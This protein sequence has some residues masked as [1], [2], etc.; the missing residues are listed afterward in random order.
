MVSMRRPGDCCA[1]P[2]PV[3]PLPAAERDALV[4][5]LRALGEPTRLEI[6]RLIAAQD[7][8]LC[9]CDVVARF[10]L[11]QPT[12]SH[13]LRVLREAEL[14]TVSRRGKWA[15]YAPNPRG[16]AILRQAAAA[17]A[18]ACLAAAR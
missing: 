2:V 12:I 17:L 3:E 4:A 8:P 5:V 14:V 1:E 6:Y 15:Y 18:P 13:H 11:Q 9:V 7:A 10:P 16:L